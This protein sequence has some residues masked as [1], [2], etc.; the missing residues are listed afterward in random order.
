MAETITIAEFLKD[1]GLNEAL[2]PGQVKFKT[3]IAEKDGNSFTIR[4]DWKSD[5]N[6]IKVEI[7]PGLTGAMPDKGD[8]A[9]YAV[10]LQ[11]KNALELDVSDIV[12]G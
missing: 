9:K 7:L 11:T 3:H 8:L 4:Y 5:V 1:A 12:N 10:W 2:A 6:T